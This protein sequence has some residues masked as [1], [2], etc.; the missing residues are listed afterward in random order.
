M[1]DIF[2]GRGGL[3]KA[4][5]ERLFA[6]STAEVTFVTGLGLNHQ[7]CAGIVFKP[8]ETANFSQ[9]IEE[10]EQL[11][12]QSGSVTGTGVVSETDSFGYRW[13][14]FKDTDF[15]DLLTT[16]N[17]VSSSLM[18]T[19]YGEQ[20]LCAVFPFKDRNQKAVYW[21]FNFKHDSFYPFV[22]LDETVKKRDTE[23]ELRLQA[24]IGA[25]LPVEPDISNWF[26]LWGI[27]I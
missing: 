24:A 16:L 10:V 13:M 22:P 23:E 8:L 21:I 4:R 3:K 1:R 7:R 12:E 6:L 5:D 15:S 2:F 19:G 11:L 18:D 9:M 17:M 14:I 20:L 26:A 25:E 27:P